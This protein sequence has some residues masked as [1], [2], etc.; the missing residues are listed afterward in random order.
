MFPQLFHRLTWLFFFC[1]F[2]F[3]FICSF[4]VSITPKYVNSLTFSN[5]N[6]SLSTSYNIIFLP[7]FLC[8]YSAV[9]FDNQTLTDILVNYFSYYDLALSNYSPSTK[10]KNTIRSRSPCLRSCSSYIIFKELSSM[11]EISF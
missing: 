3:S 4:I 10:I 1:I 9:V 7:S 8:A 5:L 11:R 6:F 2:L